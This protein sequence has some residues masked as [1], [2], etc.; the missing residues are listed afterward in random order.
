MFQFHATL[1]FLNVSWNNTKI[2]IKGLFLSFFSTIIGWKT[3]SP[4]NYHNSDH[5]NVY[6]NIFYLTVFKKMLL[7]NDAPYFFN[8]I[9]IFPTF[10]YNIYC[11][12]HTIFRSF[13][14]NFICFFLSFCML[15]VS[16][17]F[18]TIFIATFRIILFLF[19]IWYCIYFSFLF[20]SSEN[21]GKHTVKIRTATF[22]SSTYISLF[23][24]YQH[25]FLTFVVPLPIILC[26]KTA[27]SVF[28]YVVSVSFRTK[29][30]GEIEDV[31]YKYMFFCY[32][33]AK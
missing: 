18:L 31:S 12:F 30:R 27:K 1:I 15:H 23:L 21:F 17:F 6:I 19:L 4:L 9:F 2:N 33:Y 7:M 25:T 16:F 14:S 13:Y 8:V 32:N 20:F 26:I 3:F 24:C 5:K 28:P 10:Q 11:L 29:T 22:S